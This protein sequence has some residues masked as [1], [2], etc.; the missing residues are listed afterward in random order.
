[1]CIRDRYRHMASAELEPIMGVWGRSPLKL[2]AFLC[3]G[4]P[5]MAQ[6]AM[7]MNKDV[8]LTG[9]L[10]GHKRRLWVWGMEVHKRGPGAEPW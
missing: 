7:F 3:S 5:E 2:N 10:R 9:L 6:A 4:M 1:M 8:S